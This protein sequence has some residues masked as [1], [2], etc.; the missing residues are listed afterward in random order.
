SLSRAAAAARH[1]QG[2]EAERDERTARRDGGVAAHAAAA[3]AL[4]G[5]HRRRR[6]GIGRGIPRGLVGVVLL[7]PGG[8]VLLV[9]GGVVLLVPR[10]VVLLVPGGGVTVLLLLGLLAG[11]HD[12]ASIHDR[13]IAVEDE[14][15]GLAHLHAVV[16]AGDLQ[17]VLTRLEAM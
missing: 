13:V 2:A 5:G 14:V 1:E 10:R 16:F 7:V 9:R 4:L 12:G 6:V 11:E 15:D 8:V 3:A 17:I